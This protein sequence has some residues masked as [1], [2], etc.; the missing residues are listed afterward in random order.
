MVCAGL[1][2]AENKTTSTAV[3]LRHALAACKPRAIVLTLEIATMRTG[4]HRK[5]QN[6]IAARSYYSE[7]EKNRRLEPFRHFTEP[8]SNADFDAACWFEA[9]G[10]A[11]I[12]LN[13]LADQCGD[14]R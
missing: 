1:R 2:K 14:E 10:G 7:P 5:S 13:T 11:A 8:R 9:Y 6:G 3:Y 12:E 4:T